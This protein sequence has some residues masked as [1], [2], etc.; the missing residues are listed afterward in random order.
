MT[1]WK[2]ILCRLKI[3]TAQT[4]TISLRAVDFFQM[5]RIKTD[6]YEFREII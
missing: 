3:S 1:S 6:C 4:K 5:L 2:I